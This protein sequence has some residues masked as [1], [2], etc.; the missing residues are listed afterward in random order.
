LQEI[1]GKYKVLQSTYNIFFSCFLVS[2]DIIAA[3]VY[4]VENPFLNFKLSI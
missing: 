2:K 1:Y 4:C 3:A